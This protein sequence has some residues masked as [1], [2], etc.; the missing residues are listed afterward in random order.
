MHMQ[1]RNAVEEELGIRPHGHL[2]HEGH[3]SLQFIANINLE[4]EKS[5]AAEIS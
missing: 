5:E 4:S 1:S 3:C 2:Q